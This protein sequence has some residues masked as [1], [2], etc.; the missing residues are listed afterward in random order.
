MHHEQKPDEACVQR[1]PEGI[2]H[3]AAR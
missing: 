1:E 2:S 3:T